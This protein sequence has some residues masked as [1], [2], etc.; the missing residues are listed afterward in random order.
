MTRDITAALRDQVTAPALLPILLV[1]ALFDS[2]ALR[3]WNGRD[4]ITWNGEEWIGAGN[5]L[6]VG[7][8]TETQELRA[9]GS[10]V[11]LSGLST[12]ILSIALQE[13]YQ[14]RR[15]NLY[16]GAMSDGQLVADPYLLFGGVMD[17]MEISE[18]GETAAITVTAE[19]RLI[20]LE[21]PREFRYE[22]EDQ[23]SHFPGDLGLE[24]VSSIQDAPIIWGRS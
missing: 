2:G 13:P 4:P 3:L 12:E 16:L 22:H 7:E 10:S 21:R 11:T 18:T 9:V 20:D 8:M 5:L 6:S 14:G 1:E 17:V 15:A 19:S 24:Y 23:V